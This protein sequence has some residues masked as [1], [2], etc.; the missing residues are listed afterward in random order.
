[1]QQSQTTTP[2]TLIITTTTTATATATSTTA[3]ATATQNDSYKHQSKVI[4]MGSYLYQYWKQNYYQPYHRGPE[5]PSVVSTVEEEEEEEDKNIHDTTVKVSMTNQTHFLDS[6]SSEEEELFVDMEP[7]EDE[8]YDYYDQD[9]DKE[10]PSPLPSSTFPLYA[11]GKAKGGQEQQQQQ[12]QQQQHLGVDDDREEPSSS[13]SGCRSESTTAPTECLRQSR[14]C[15]PGFFKFPAVSF[16]IVVVFM[17][18]IFVAVPVGVGITKILQNQQ[19]E[20]CFHECDGDDYITLSPTTGPPPPSQDDDDDDDIQEVDDDHAT[21]YP[22]IDSVPPQTGTYKYGAQYV[23]KIEH[24]TSSSQ[25]PPTVPRIQYLCRGH[26]RYIHAHSDVLNNKRFQCLDVDDGTYRG[27]ECYHVCGSTEDCRYWW[28]NNPSERPTIE[29]WNRSALWY[30]CLGDSL[31]EVQAKMVWEDTHN[32]NQQHGS[33][34]GVGES[35]MKL[36][37][38]EIRSDYGEYEDIMDLIHEGYFPPTDVSGDYISINL[39]NNALVELSPASPTD[40]GY[41]VWTGVEDCARDAMCDVEF[42]PV[43]IESSDPSDFPSS[44]IQQYK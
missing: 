4:I 9:H 38:L 31:S 43:V 21:T 29:E 12:Q 13:F 26:F 19:K 18:F 11:I 25:T 1:M 15:R 17:V 6:R 37:R 44:Y 10:R 23:V 40:G 42:G 8:S 32:E 14:R 30:E 35:N 41:Y 5:I 24:V 2:T 36:A 16:C 34:I 27:V 33:R 28:N 39:D 7:Y 3:T 22:A 20:E